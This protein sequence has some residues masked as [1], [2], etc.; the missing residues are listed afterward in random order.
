VQR[1]HQAGT[2]CTNGSL[3][4][5]DRKSCCPRSESDLHFAVEQLIANNNFTSLFLSGKP[6]RLL[7]SWDTG[8]DCKF[9]P[10]EPELHC[11]HNPQ[12][13]LS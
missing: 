3:D 9:S 6:A 2:F 1:L 10:Q 4:D 13:L 5:Y 8:L 12:A 11:P 7:K